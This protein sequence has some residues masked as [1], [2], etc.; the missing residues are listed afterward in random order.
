MICSLRVCPGRQYASAGQVWARSYAAF[1]MFVDV[2]TW[3]AALHYSTGCSCTTVAPSALLHPAPLTR[4][5]LGLRG[6]ALLQL[7]L[8][9]LLPPNEEHRQVQAELAVLCGGAL[10]QPQPGV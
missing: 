3:K 9:L 7:L 5:L 10:L 4:L 2:Q 6:L 1:S 8:G